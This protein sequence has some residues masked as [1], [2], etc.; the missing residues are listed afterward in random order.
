MRLRGGDHVILLR[1]YNLINLQEDHAVFD[2]IP[3]TLA[4][5]LYDLSFVFLVSGST[6]LFIPFLLPLLLCFGILVLSTKT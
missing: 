4:I 2:F 3:K 1:S 6:L 5:E